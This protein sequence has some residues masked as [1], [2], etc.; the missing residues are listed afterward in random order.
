MRTQWTTKG[1][2]DARSSCSCYR[3]L[4][5]YLRNFGGGGVVNSPYPPSVRH[6]LLLIAFVF[7]FKQTMNMETV[8]FVSI[9]DK[10]LTIYGR[11]Q[12]RR[13]SRSL[14]EMHIS[15]FQCIIFHDR[16]V[17]F[18]IFYLHACL[19]SI[20][21]THSLAWKQFWGNGICSS[22]RHLTAWPLVDSLIH[23]AFLQ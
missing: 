21:I 20:T 8:R 18:E 19:I 3:G 17:M 5:R 16:S 9:F 10:Y 6:W 23:N 14:C 22:K 13:A 15:C 1:N 4:H 11:D 2:R 12:Q 7:I